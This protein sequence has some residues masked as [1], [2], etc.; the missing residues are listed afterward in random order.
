MDH[1]KIE[2]PGITAGP[3]PQSYVIGPTD[4]LYVDVYGQPTMGSPRTT[5]ENQVLGSRVDGHGRIQLPLVGSVHVGGMTAAQAQQ[6]LQRLYG[7]IIAEPWVV[8]E[9]VRHQSQP[10]Y[11]V[12]QF[13]DAGIHYMDRPTSLMQAVAMGR[14]TDS[15]DLRGARLIRGR[16]TLPVDIYGLLR[17]GELQQ[18]L[19]LRADDTVYVP[20]ERDQQVFVLGDVGQP[21]PVPMINGRLTLTQAL[22]A[23][24]NF[25][26][27]G[28][29]L[30]QVRIIRSIT[31]TRGE[32][33]L[34]D[35]QRILRGEALPFQLN[36]GDVV[37]IP[38]D[39]LGDWNDS[40]RELIPTLSLVSH[41]LTPFVQ[42]KFLSE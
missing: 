20:D 12:G 27:T 7:K 31:P 42:V 39:Q 19:W 3:P 17:E 1:R 36:S 16:R 5:G 37:Y 6:K 41:L 21:G 28:S 23:A 33:L 30:H 18:N 4:V 38:R 40:I 13:E 11:L 8:V 10:V 35:L 25:K 26:R 22:A 24:G 32:L 29:D 15:A 9:V 2:V 14:L 34:V